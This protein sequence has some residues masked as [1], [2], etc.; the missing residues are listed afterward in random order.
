MLLQ[1][2]SKTE[3]KPIWH[4]VSCLLEDDGQAILNLEDLRETGFDFNPRLLHVHLSRTN[5]Y[6]LSS[7]QFEDIDIVLENRLELRY[8]PVSKDD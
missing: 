5:F 8:K 7:G 4:D 3:G 6:Q 2:Q 1:L